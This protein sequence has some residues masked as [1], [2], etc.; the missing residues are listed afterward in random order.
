MDYRNMSIEELD[1]K[2]KELK[3][4]YYDIDMRK[5]AIKEEISLIES[6]RKEKD[7]QSEV[8]METPVEEVNEV[9]T[10]TPIAPQ[11]ETEVQENV[12][13]EIPQAEAPV[14]ETTES[15]EVTPIAPQVETEVQENAQVEIPQAEAPVV[16]ATESATV[17]PLVPQVETEVQENAQAEIPQA[18][19]PVQEVSTEVNVDISMQQ[20][21]VQPPIAPQGVEIANV[22]EKNVSNEV[23]MK[24]DSNNPMAI[25]ITPLQGEKL[26]KSREATK[27]EINE[28]ISMP[29][30]NMATNIEAATTV[31]PVAGAPVEQATESAVVT[32]I[33]PQGEAV[34]KEELNKKL[35][36][37]IEQLKTVTDEN[38]ANEINN[39]IS[40]LTKKLAA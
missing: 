29:Q 6:I 7:N 32:P 30:K 35:E 4:E 1:A 8:A 2:E 23:Y 25:R 20:P 19:N 26:R 12:Q 28:L 22:E 17:T 3:V 13:V 21:M 39:Q 15:A 10:V 34:D 24:M 27:T 40:V 31:I 14:V 16:E 18:E 37:M 5:T 38:E 11:V 33:A 36:S 9:A